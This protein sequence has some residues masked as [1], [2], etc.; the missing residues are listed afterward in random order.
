MRDYTKI[1]AETLEILIDYAIDHFFSEPVN[2]E[3]QNLHNGYKR[4]IIKCSRCG[5]RLGRM[6]KDPKGNLIG[7]KICENFPEC[8]ECKEDIK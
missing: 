8:S 7:Y 2:V 4:F 5:A 6:S 3:C 1:H